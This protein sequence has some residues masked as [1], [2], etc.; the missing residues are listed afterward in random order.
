MLF[1]SRHERINVDTRAATQLWVTDRH[2][3][4]FVATRSRLDD[5]LNALVPKRSR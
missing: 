2:Q 3:A 5:M 1:A 4:D